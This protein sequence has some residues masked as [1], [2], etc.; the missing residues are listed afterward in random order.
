[1]TVQ[2]PPDSWR[3]FAGWLPNLAPGRYQDRDVFERSNRPSNG[4]FGILNSIRAHPTLVSSRPTDTSD[5][6]EVAADRFADHLRWSTA[7]SPTAAAGDRRDKDESSRPTH[8][9]RAQPMRLSAWDQSKPTVFQT[10]PACTS[11]STAKFFMANWQW[12]FATVI[13]LGGGLGAWIALLH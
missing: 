3:L 13:G 4:V 10:A 9:Q 2:T 8:L 12:L 11:M 7:P 1:M 5:A 6:E